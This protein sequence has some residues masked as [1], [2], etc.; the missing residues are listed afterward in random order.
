[1][2]ETKMWNLNWHLGGGGRRGGNLNPRVAQ[3][4]QRDG[5][6]Q[7]VIIFLEVQWYLL[8]IFTTDSKKSSLTFNSKMKHT[9]ET[10]MKNVI[11][12][13]MSKY[14]FDAL[15]K[16]IVKD[17]NLW[18]I[19]YWVVHFVIFRNESPSTIVTIKFVQFPV[20]L[21]EIYFKWKWVQ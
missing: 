16:A 6:C 12:I 4:L 7:K 8:V 17:I 5:C 15:W 18:T 13:T 11:K 21:S 9:M 20:H 1:M 14:S 3:L 19:S 2:I 10:K